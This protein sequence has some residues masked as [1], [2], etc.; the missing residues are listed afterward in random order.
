MN[1]P[2]LPSLRILVLAAGFSHRLGQPKALARAHGVSLIRR[3]TLLLAPF[4]AAR[5][6]LVVPPR[7]ARYQVELRGI[8][9]DFAVNRRRAQGLSSSVRCGIAHVRYA[10]AVLLVPV[11]L[12]RL[13]PRDI[14]RLVQRWRGARRRVAV[15]R[16]GAHLGAPLILPRWLFTPALRIE[17]DVGLREFIRRLAAQHLMPVSMSSAQADID[18]A[19]DL[20]SARRRF[21]LSDLSL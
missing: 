8:D 20:R 18:T 14:A 16:L 10:S 12:A 6:V 5:P 19:L 1:G 17:G 21:T 11:D 9:V 13:R 4:T 3:A 15:A 7:S 2:A